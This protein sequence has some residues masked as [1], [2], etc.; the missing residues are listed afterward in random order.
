MRPVPSTDAD[1]LIFNRATVKSFFLEAVSSN[2]SGTGV[3][4][5]SFWFGA[6]GRDA[7][8][9]SRRCAVS[10]LR[11]L[12]SGTDALPLALTDSAVNHQMP[13]ADDVDA[14]LIQFGLRQLLR[15]FVR[16]KCRQQTVVEVPL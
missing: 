16:R 7:R 1:R 4:P 3:P 11:S 15:Y 12:E 5:V 9:M 2:G 6:N 13:V 8:A 10:M 14:E